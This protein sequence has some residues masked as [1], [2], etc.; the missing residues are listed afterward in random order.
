MPP[1]LSHL[2]D[3]TRASHDLLDADFGSLDLTE[4]T[5]Y[6]RF[7]SGHAIGI[8]PLF[9]TFRLFVERD[10]E[11]ACPDYPAMLRA[12]LAAIGIDADALHHIAEPTALEPAATG[13]VIAGSRLGL[14]MLA[15]GGYWGRS[16]GLP[17]AYMDDQQGLAIWKETAAWLKQDVPDDERAERERSAAVAA[18]DTFRH[19]FAASAAEPAQ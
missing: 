2:R 12:D 3:A 8:A 14:G 4:R 19:A 15:R 10:L 17:S 13:Y 5:G 18:F 11:L 9:G 1:L 6:A 16:N 7:L